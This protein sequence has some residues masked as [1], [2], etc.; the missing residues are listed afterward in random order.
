M[1]VCLSLPFL[2]AS[3]HSN[4]L[5][6]PFLREKV[7]TALINKPIIP[8]NIKLLTKVKNIDPNM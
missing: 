8:H 5:L 3:F 2:K 1:Q 7:Q 6:I 4:D